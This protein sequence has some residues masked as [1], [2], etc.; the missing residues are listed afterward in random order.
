MG[1]YLDLYSFYVTIK[2]S[3]FLKYQSF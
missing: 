2:E 1:I 3:D